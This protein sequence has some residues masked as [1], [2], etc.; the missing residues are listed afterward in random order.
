MARS[1]GLASAFW[2]YCL[3]AYLRSVWSRILGRPTPLTHHLEM[4]LR[5]LPVLRSNAARDVQ[6]TR[7]SKAC[8]Q[9]ALHRTRHESLP[10]PAP[11]LH[12]GERCYEPEF[13]LLVPQLEA[14]K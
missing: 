6:P 9:S 2:A 14:G 7:R 12:C 8:S 10:S 13:Y 4:A 5:S 1:P 3:V 11:S